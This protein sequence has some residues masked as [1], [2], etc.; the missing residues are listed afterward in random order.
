MPDLLAGTVHRDDRLLPAWRGE[1]HRRLAR[2]EAGEALGVGDRVRVVVEVWLQLVGLRQPFL[3]RPGLEVAADHV[4]DQ[5]SGPIGPA[6]R[7]RRPG[8]RPEA[9]LEALDQWLNVRAP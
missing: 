4:A 7:W 8:S 2:L 9:V 1:D 3:P 6:A 5:M